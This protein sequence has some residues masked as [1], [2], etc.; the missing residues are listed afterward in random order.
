MTETLDVVREVAAIDAA[1]VERG[2]ATRAEGAKAYLKSDLEFHG[3]D[4]KGIRATVREV[5]ARNPDLNH[6]GL[7][8]LIRGL[9]EV[10]VFEMRA[11]AVGLCERRPDLI[12]P[13]D[14][15]WIEEL[16][17]GSKTWALVDWLCTKVAGP[18]V[19]N[20]PK[21]KRALKRWAADDDFW[22]RRSAMLSLLT[23]LRAGAGDFD[24]FARFAS[25]MIEE[26]EF[27]IRK[28]I[29]W[30]LRE[31]AKKRPQLT[32]DFLSEEVDRVAGLTLREG[33]KYLPEEQREELM[34]RYRAR[35]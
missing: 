18:I 29:G 5:Y 15:V 16:L 8:D 31:V 6:D 3:V 26:K 1:L 27:F 32:Y 21:T 30:V 17:R 2:T 4:A 12:G 28:A 7:V 24:L 20:H 13:D 34:T 22:I 9:W 14:L 10:R 25:S 19:S 35:K 11:V 23:D 33:A